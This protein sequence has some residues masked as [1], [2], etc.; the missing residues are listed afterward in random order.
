M[1]GQRILLSRLA[2]RQ[3]VCVHRYRSMDLGR[4][5]TN[6]GVVLQGDSQ[7]FDKFKGNPDPRA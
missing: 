3:L 1:A 5:W 2:D 4:T 6:L 7:M